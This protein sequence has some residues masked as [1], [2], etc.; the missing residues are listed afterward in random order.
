V[1][2]GTNYAIINCNVGGVLKGKIFEHLTFSK[3]KHNESTKN[4]KT[5]N[6]K[7]IKNATLIS[8][9][10]IDN[11]L[12]ICYNYIVRNTTVKSKIVEAEIPLVTGKAYEVE[13]EVFGNV[14]GV[15]IEQ[16]FALYGGKK[17]S[18]ETTIR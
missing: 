4:T 18:K 8:S 16:N 15:L 14:T 3:T 17:V 11:I 9:A 5:I 10:N 1:E 12:N 2:S 13:T 7:T 6:K